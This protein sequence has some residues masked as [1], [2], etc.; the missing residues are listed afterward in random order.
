MSKNCILVL[1]INPSVSLV[2]L[3][4][5]KNQT[6]RKMKKTVLLI[7]V[8]VLSLAKL[9]SQDLPNPPANLQTLPAGSYIIPMDNYLQS[10]GNSIG[11]GKFNLTAYGLIVHL[12]N[13]DVKVKWAIKAGKVKDGTDFTTTAQ[14]FK[15]SLLTASA[16]DFIS[17]P[18]V[19]YAND[20]LGVASIINN[21]YTQH[22][23]TGSARPR[24]FRTT[25]ATPNVDI[26]YDMA[27][28]KPKAAILTD[29]GNEQI[30]I[31][32]MGA[33]AIP[34]T[35]YSTSTGADLMNN[36][37]TFAS[38][39][40]NDK[41]GAQVDAAVQGV[42][43]FVLHGRNFLAECAAI[44]TYENNQYG[45]FQTTDGLVKANQNLSNNLSYP[46]ADL[47]YYQF[48]GDYN[49]SSGGSVKNWE[50]VT[51]S[52][53]SSDVTGTGTNTDIQAA[54]ISK[55]VSGPGG[56]VY[57]LGNHSFSTGSDAGING[58]RMYMN[59][60]MTP[61]APAAFCSL[62]VSTLPVKLIT[63]QGFR[64][65]A[66]I[67]LQW[68]VADNEIADQFEV[69]RSTDGTNFSEAAV[70]FSSEKVG[71]ENYMYYENNTADRVMY[72]LKMIDKSGVVEYSKILVFTNKS[73]QNY[74]LR[75]VN[76]PVIDKLT[77]SFETATNQ[78]MTVSVLDMM[79][80]QVMTQKVNG[81]TGSNLVNFALPA[82]LNA[83]LYV[84]DLFDGVNHSNAKFIKN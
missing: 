77:L 29:G 18:F 57:Y 11:Q 31:D 12:L 56:M 52:N 79:G 7:S 84:V 58:I 15:P 23:L 20:T 22:G 81:Y 76:N 70:V 30:H 37:Y 49:A 71:T 65:D 47:S 63:F 13:Y 5:E 53:A 43:N 67:T 59:A 40:H 24:V 73:G 83:G 51:T 41:T 78:V 6:L 35:N 75:V 44:T 14:E 21:F 64:K 32:F 2:N 28:F 19:I 50:P 10:D 25:V 17:G 66:K 69:E 45:K 82:S 27:H 8:L 62:N 9:Q 33:A 54:S 38:E 1:S 61:P 26:R 74:D 48:E 80:R 60:F 39:P 36:C 3:P 4:V 34:S 55:L 68:Q 46:Y 72:R 16:Y 42:R